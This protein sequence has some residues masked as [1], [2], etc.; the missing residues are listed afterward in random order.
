MM[1]EF[2][3]PL[4]DTSYDPIGNPSGTA[5]QAVYAIAGISMTLLLISIANTNVVPKVQQLLANLTG[6]NVGE[7]GFSVGSS[8]GGL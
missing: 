3:D 7:G 8:G 1:P 4:T 6:A 5:I 2:T